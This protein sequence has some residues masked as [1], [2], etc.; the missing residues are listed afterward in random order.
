MLE[1]VFNLDSSF[2]LNGHTYA[3]LI[4]EVVKFIYTIT[5]LA[6]QILFGRSNAGARGGQGI[7]LASGR[8]N[9]CGISGEHE[10]ERPGGRKRRWDLNGF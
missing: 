9:A 4:K 1:L 5:F 8:R 3:Y 10:G 7:R 6:G 2:F